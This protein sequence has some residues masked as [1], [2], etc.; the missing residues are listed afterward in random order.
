[1][2]WRLPRVVDEIGGQVRSFQSFRAA[3]WSRCGRGEAP[4]AGVALA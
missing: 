4:I 2:P 1:M 3:S